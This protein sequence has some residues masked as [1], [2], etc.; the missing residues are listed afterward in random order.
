MAQV[1][2]RFGNASNDAGVQKQL[3]AEHFVPQVP[4]ETGIPFL[5]APFGDPLV[6]IGRHPAEVSCK[7]Q[8]TLRARNAVQP[9]VEL[10]LRVML[11]RPRTKSK[12]VP[13]CRLL[14]TWKR[15]KWYKAGRLVSGWPG[16]RLLISLISLSSSSNWDRSRGVRPEKVKNLTRSAMQLYSCR[17]FSLPIFADDHENSCSQLQPVVF[18]SFLI[19]HFGLLS[20]TS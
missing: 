5:V 20:T 1:F 14:R 12:Q 9:P 17:F 19:I 15:Y 10:S 2:G 3:V 4:I 11:G 6:G 16:F 13:I 18:R 7:L 8:A